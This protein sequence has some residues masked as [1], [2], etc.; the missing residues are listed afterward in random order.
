MTISMS[1]L[2]S[3]GAAKIDADAAEVAAGG[4]DE[5]GEWI[6]HQ[7]RQAGQGEVAGAESDH[8]GHGGLPGFQITQDLS[9]RADEGL[10][11]CGQA[12]RSAAGVWNRAAP[13]SDSSSRTARERAGCDT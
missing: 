3:S 9:G 10:T 11:G 7:R 6:G 4:P 5:W 13:S 1:S 8:R 2:A 12:H